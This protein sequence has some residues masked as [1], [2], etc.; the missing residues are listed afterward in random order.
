MSSVADPGTYMKL[1]AGTRVLW[2]ALD[3]DTADLKLLKDA[4]SVGAVGRTSSFVE[5]TRLIDTEKKFISDM[6]EATST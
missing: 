6:P 4:D 1:P 2:G 3:D 5:A